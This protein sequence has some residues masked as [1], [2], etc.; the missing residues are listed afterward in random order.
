MAGSHIAG[1]AA[2]M[3]NWGTWVDFPQPVSPASKRISTSTG[4]NHWLNDRIHQS[5][6]YPSFIYLSTSLIDRLIEAT[7][8]VFNFFLHLQMN[9]LQATGV[10]STC[11]APISLQRRFVQPWVVQRKRWRRS[12]QFRYFAMELEIDSVW[13]RN[14]QQLIGVSRCTSERNLWEKESASMNMVD[15]RYCEVY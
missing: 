3:R 11:F 10:D 12:E 13:Y 8:C 4:E 1:E 15:F 2:S 7:T 6:T 9:N 14:V 5:I